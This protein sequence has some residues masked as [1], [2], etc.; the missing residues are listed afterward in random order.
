[1]VYRTLNYLAAVEGIEVLV[2]PGFVYPLQSSTQ[3][4]QDVERFISAHLPIKFAVFSHIESVPSTVLPV[5]ALAEMAHSYN[6]SVL[7]D[8]AHSLGNIDVDLYSINADY[9]VATAYKWLFAPKGTAFLWVKKNLQ[10]N[11]VPTV[12]SAR[13]VTSNFQPNFRYTG[14][15]DYTQFCTIPEAFAFRER[16]GG[17][18][19]IKEYNH[20]LAWSGVQLLSKMW[21][22]TLA[23]PEEL[24]SAMADVGFLT[25]DTTISSWVQ[26]EI[27][28][29]YNEMLLLYT[30][31]DGSNWARICGQIYLELSDFEDLGNRVL[32]LFA[33]YQASPPQAKQVVV[34][35]E[36][37]V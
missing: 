15:R 22:T 19:A 21:N 17:D 26:N 12:I 30:L 13:Y 2:V 33:E 7:I 37:L 25:N 34:H 14:T 23:A 27:W 9:Y 16:V 20:N 6:I 5:K 31:P 32:Q 11:I 35:T 36:N 4:V 1:M 24:S 18:K 28:T 3:I 29:R 10:S 8:G